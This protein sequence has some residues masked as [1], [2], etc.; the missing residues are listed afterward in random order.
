[1]SERKP[2][3]V[4]LPATTASKL[5]RFAFELGISKQ[6]LVT[7]LLERRLPQSA[8]R[9]VTVES[10]DD[11]MAVGHHSFVPAS[12]PDVLTIGEVAD[13]LRVGEDMV[14]AMAESGEL[15][16]RKLGDEW[17][18]TRAAVLRWLGAEDEES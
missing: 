12:Q 2:L 10:V 17:R 11:A 4:R 1:M 16:G 9:R 18:F 14:T 5:D 3:Y 6:D 8:T 7:D 15:P 13:L